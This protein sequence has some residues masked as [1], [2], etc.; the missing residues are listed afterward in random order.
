MNQVG[1]GRPDFRDQGA[2]ISRSRYN[3]VA[4]LDPRIQHVF[5]HAPGR[6]GDPRIKKNCTQ[7]PCGCQDKRAGFGAPLSDP[8]LRTA[9]GAYALHNH[10]APTAAQIEAVKRVLRVVKK[11]G[12]GIQRFQHLEP[13]DFESSRMTGT[14]PFE[15]EGDTPS[16]FNVEEATCSSGSGRMGHPTVGRKAEEHGTTSQDMSFVSSGDFTMDFGGVVAPDTTAAREETLRFAWYPY[17]KDDGGQLTYRGINSMIRSWGTSRTQRVFWHHGHGASH[18]FFLNAVRMI[19]VYRQQIRNRNEDCPDARER[20][21]ERLDELGYKFYI[22]NG[23]DCSSTPL[24]I[25][26]P[27]DGS[28]FPESISLT[29]GSFGWYNSVTKNIHLCA[30]HLNGHAH[31]ADSLLAYAH[32]AYWY[33][34]NGHAE[35]LEQAW[36]F[37]VQAKYLGRLSL[38]CVASI[39]TTILHEM[40]HR[41]YGVEHCKK[42]CCQAAISLRW[43]CRVFSGLGLYAADSVNRI[44]RNLGRV[45]I[46]RNSKCKD[47]MFGAPEAFEGLCSMTHPGIQGDFEAWTV[48]GPWMYPQGCEPTVSDGF[49]GEPSF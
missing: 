14:L 42:G 5:S 1:K 35:D 19:D 21:G 10:K 24:A 38:G 41:V 40:L 45:T 7:S 18:R 23:W 48:E 22:D 49:W 2:N 4:A 25:T 29:D 33:V 46:G 9:E 34:L 11:S 30:N 26:F 13:Y 31:V 28:G 37:F 47:P 16:N 43:M 27:T 39:S 32:Q 20:V 6:S 44:D 36:D 12:K 8:R 17:Y 15:E 3:L